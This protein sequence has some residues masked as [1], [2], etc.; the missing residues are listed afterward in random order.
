MNSPHIER[1][2]E[3]M[4]GRLLK[5]GGSRWQVACVRCDIQARMV[6][7]GDYPQAA[8]FL[9]HDGWTEKGNIWRCPAC[10]GANDGEEAGVDAYPA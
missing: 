4:S 5:M 1:N 3:L 10:G 8:A 2:P 9:R 6:V 7:K